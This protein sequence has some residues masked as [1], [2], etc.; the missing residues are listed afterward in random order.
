MKIN[1][2]TIRLEKEADHRAVEALVRD[3]FWNWV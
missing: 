1:D 3:S 2:Y